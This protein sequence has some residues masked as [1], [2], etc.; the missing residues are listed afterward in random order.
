[1][2]YFFIFIYPFIHSFFIYTSLSE[3]DNY[4][5]FLLA[6]PIYILI[7]EVKIDA[8]TFI[9]FIN[10]TALSLGPVAL[11][12]NL[13]DD[14]T[15]IRGFT[16]STIIFGNISILFCALSYFSINYFRNNNL[17]YQY[18]PHLASLSSFVAWSYSD[19]RGS[20]FALLGLIIIFIL[21]KKSRSQFFVH[22][23]KT[24]FIIISFISLI[25]IFS[26]SHIRIIDAYT[27]SYN[28]FSKDIQHDHRHSGSIVPRLSLWKGS[29]N[30]ISDNLFLGVGLNNFNSELEKQIKYKKINPIRYDYG[31]GPSQ[32]RVANLTAGLN[33]AH[34]QYLDTFVKI[35]FLG[36]IAL[37]YFLI[38]HLIFFLKHYSRD[39]HNIYARLG[40]ISIL[41]YMLFMLTHTITSHHQSTLFMVTLMVILS[42]L[43]N[44]FFHKGR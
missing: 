21:F 3:V 4:L 36:F 32:K 1:L 23:K 44:N 17:S 43:C 35:G 12:F 2:S 42:G 5:R 8:D 25:F 13:T 28:Y 9:Y 11:Y 39:N 37:L 10:I 14:V 16:S 33:H 29:I 31:S 41:M 18:M 38:I 19:T 24:A 34:N 40:I 20:L 22:C 26:N 30:I 7:R 27:S 6:I 15:R